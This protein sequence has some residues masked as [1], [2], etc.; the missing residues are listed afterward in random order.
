MNEI[1]KCMERIK[2]YLAEHRPP[3]GEAIESRIKIFVEKRKKPVNAADMLNE[4]DINK[5]I[6]ENIN[7]ITFVKLITKYKEDR[8]YTNN[9]LCKMAGLDRRHYS[10]MINDSKYS[11]RRSTAISLGMALKLERDEFDLLLASAGYILSESSVSDLIIGFCIENEIYNVIDVNV[12]LFR[13]NQK[14]LTNN[15]E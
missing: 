3:P 15:I 6:N 1:E 4:E 12:I 9:E 10:R 13:A 11:P 7:K 14:V 2:K 5:Y 8:N